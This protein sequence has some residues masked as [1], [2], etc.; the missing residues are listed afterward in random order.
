MKCSMEVYSEKLPSV[1][2]TPQ[3]LLLQENMDS[4]SFRTFAELACHFLRRP[5]ETEEHYSELFDELLELMF[6]LKNGKIPSL[7]TKKSNQLENGM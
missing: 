6:R 2:D 5:L 1:R 4:E 7:I 3:L